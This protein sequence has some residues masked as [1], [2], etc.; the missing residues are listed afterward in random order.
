M[1]LEI[2]LR[3]LD[4]V[5][6]RMGAPRSKWTISGGFLTDRETL[7]REL[8]SG[9]EVSLEEIGA[10]HSLLEYKG[11]QVLLYIKDTRSSR[12]T[13]IN[14]PEDSRRF[15]FAECSTLEAM[16]QARRFDKYHVANRVDGKFLCA[17]IDP[18]TGK[19]GEVEAALKVCRNC[20]RLV[21]WEGYGVTGSKTAIWERF[22]I[23]NLIRVYQTFFYNKPNRDQYANVS[24]TYV[25]DWPNISKGY[26]ERRGWKC[27]E[28]NVDLSSQKR[29]LHSHHINGV[30]GDNSDR[31]LQALCVLCHANQPQHGHMRCT[32][33][34]RI[35][36]EQLRRRQRSLEF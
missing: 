36:I 4:A 2:D 20:L 23:A 1:K 19:T 13:L 6:R 3:P 26:K 27:E 5:M 28:C 12:D 15:H 21:E 33:D 14:H 25:T 34:E 9:I 29:L 18:E 7:S 22:D 8:V 35:T 32:D 10:R 11:E 17:W 30:L 24:S 31:N 16:R